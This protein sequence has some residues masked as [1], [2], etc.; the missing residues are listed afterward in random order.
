MLTSLVVIVNKVKGKKQ[1]SKM[2]FLELIG[3][4]I[5][6]MRNTSS[7]MLPNVSPIVKCFFFLFFTPLGDVVGCL[8]DFHSPRKSLICVV[9]NDRIIYRRWVSIKAEVLYPIINVWWGPVE[10]HVDWLSQ[11]PP[12]LSMVSCSTV[13]H[14][15]HRWILLGYSI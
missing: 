9:K 8:V 13:A 11:S 1:C 15:I 10:L 5:Q 7:Q 2:C 3:S 6:E 4:F 12:S 14:G